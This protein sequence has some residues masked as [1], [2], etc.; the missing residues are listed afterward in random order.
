MSCGVAIFVKTPQLT[1]VKTRLWPCLGRSRAE[2]L[3]RI[4]AKAVASVVAQAGPVTKAQAYWA[5]A[6]EAAVH[7]E[8][9]ES[10]PCLAQ[11]E[12]GLGERMAHVYAALRRRHYAAI[13]V[14]ADAPQITASHLRRATDW[15][16]N[17]ESRLVIGPA[18]DGGFWLFGGNCPLPASAWSQV[19][20]SATDTAA[21][22]VRAM[23]GVGPWRTLETL[24]DIDTARDLEPALAALTLLDMPTPAQA[25][26]SAWLANLPELYA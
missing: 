2:A 13:L 25:Q 3:Y 24:R 16:D 17:S 12:G 20:Y 1:P 26:L 10:I 4:S 8:F 15:L 22:F 18:E 21:Q 19:H 11:G 9:W 5:V 23:D 7:V 6:E 14:G